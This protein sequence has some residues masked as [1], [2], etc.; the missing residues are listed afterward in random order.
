MKYDMYRRSRP[1]AQIIM[2]FQIEPLFCN[3]IRKNVPNYQDC[4]VMSPDEVGVKRVIMIADDLDMDYA[5][6]NSRR[7]NR[8]GLHQIKGK[9]HSRLNHQ[10]LSE[11]WKIVEVEES[12]EQNKT[13]SVNDS[14][15]ETDED[16]SYDLHDILRTLELEKGFDVNHD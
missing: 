8:K 7:K 13:Q 15:Q 6:I 11:T 10:H 12:S 14:L 16:A 1:F 9:R 3:W 2:L 5:V 4:V